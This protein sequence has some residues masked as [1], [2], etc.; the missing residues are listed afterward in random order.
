[1]NNFKVKLTVLMPV[2]NA[3]KY[4]IEAIESIINQSYQQF[5]FL[6]ID[7]GSTDNSLNIIKSFADPR[8]HLI[9]FQKN[10][11]L[12]YALNEGIRMAKGDYIAR[13]DADDVSHP[14]RLKI[15]MDFLQK[16]SDVVLLG[17]DYQVIDER[18]KKCEYRSTLVKD[19][20]IRKSLCVTN[21]FAHGATIFRKQEA[22]AVGGYDSNFFLAE[23]LELWIKL[24]KLGKLANIPLPLYNWRLLKSSESSVNRKLMA[25]TS[26]KIKTRNWREFGQ[27]GPMPLDQS[28]KE[29][30]LKELEFGSEQFKRYH[31]ITLLIRFALGYEQRNKMKI[32]L[33]HILFAFKFKPNFLLKICLVCLTIFPL[34]WLIKNA[35]LSIPASYKRLRQYL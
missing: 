1:V 22:L 24:A 28:D 12:I 20:L 35:L 21:P 34:S 30:L 3:E 8:I 9:R 4:L 14:D 23:D 25:K 33:K 7:D 5:E 27:M 11:K 32:K 10:N 2:Y 18:S 26:L 31:L 16:H 19:A 15:Q 17:S 6:I 29:L 13:M